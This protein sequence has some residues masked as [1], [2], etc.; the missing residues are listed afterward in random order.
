MDRDARRLGLREFLKVRRARLQPAD[1][2]LRSSGRRRV[3]G[4]RRSEVA[5]LVGVSLGWY[6]LFEMGTSDRRF[7]AAF[8]QRVADALRLDRE[9]TAT[10]FRL[11]LPEVAAATEVV[12]RSAR[13]GALQHMAHIRD[14]ARRVGGA[15]S[16][17]EGTTAALETV[18]SILAP[19]CISVANLTHVADTPV[20]LAVGPRANVAGP[21]LARTVLSVNRPVERG[22][23]VLCENAPDNAAARCHAAHPVRVINPDG[24]IGVG[25]HDPQVDD[26]CDFNSG[27]QQRSSLVVGL[28]QRGVFHGNLVAF[29]SRPKLHT[30]L[31]I[32]A[33][34]TISAILEL[35]GARADPSWAPVER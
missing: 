21:V 17:V 30:D 6:E 7:S 34:L 2:G 4:L 3:P 19:D 18:Q 31:E 8:V 27:L 12:E 28:F 16:F 13:D 35:A 11:A 1:L 5:E 15:S 9:D 29:W 10:L 33:L 24:T 14:L 26:Y 22:G 20:A 32:E 23:A 25:I